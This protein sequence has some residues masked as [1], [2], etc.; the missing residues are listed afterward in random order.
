MYDAM[1][2]NFWFG[3]KWFYIKHNG[4]PPKCPDDLTSNGKR[5]INQVMIV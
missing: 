3:K 4:S 5:F 1:P 2:G